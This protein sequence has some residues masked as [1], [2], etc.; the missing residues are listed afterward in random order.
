ME[1]VSR[2]VTNI[3]AVTGI[4]TVKS[5]EDDDTVV[6]TFIKQNDNIREVLVLKGPIGY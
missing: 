6:D 3:E 4:T 5:K 1:N 2:V